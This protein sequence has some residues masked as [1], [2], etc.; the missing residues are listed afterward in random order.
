MAKRDYYE[1]LG[2]ERSAT[3]DQLK[4]AYRK[5]ALELHPD[6]N[7]DN[8][9][10]EEGFKQAS[11]AFAVLSDPQKRERYDA[12]GHAGLEAAGFSG[13]S[14]LGS[15][16]DQFRD[17][18]GGGDVFGFGDLFGGGRRGR[19]DGPQRGADLRAMIELTLAE[20]AFGTKKELAL[21]HPAPCPKCEGSG[22]APGSKRETCATCQGRGQVAHSR[23][24]FVLST[25]CPKCHGEGSTVQQPCP[26]CRGHGEVNVE[27]RVKVT[28]PAG[29]DDGQTLRVAGQG[30]PGRRAG[31]AGHLYVTVQVAPHAEL[32]RDGNDLVYELTLTFPEA[33]LGAEVQVPKLDGGHATVKVPAG[34]QPGESVVLEGQGVPRIDSR[35][36]GNLVAVVH[37]DVPKKLDGKTKK[38]IQELAKELGPSRAK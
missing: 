12:Y 28:V 15:I 32:T 18:F 26:D 10:A 16:F 31:P 11:E 22:A 19:R 25:T 27:R 5:L 8:P 2:V 36:R 9:Q 24:A 33:A 7:P 34:I 20:A 37:V 1:V 6:R 3:A 17:I 23:G 4:K 13:V 35:G 14:D 38:L 29:I 21:A 30:Q